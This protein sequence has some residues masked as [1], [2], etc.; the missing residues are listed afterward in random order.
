MIRC[1]V[2]DFDGVLVDSNAVKHHA[3]FDVFAPVP[4]AAAIVAEVLRTH[5]FGNRYDVIGAVLRRLGEIR[6]TDEGAAVARYAERYNEI[7]EEHAATCAEIDGASA[8]LRR[9]AD[10]TPLYVNSATPEAPLRRIVAR[11]AWQGLFR[12]VFG[13]PA[14]KV[15]NLERAWRDAGVDAAEAL[16]V[17]DREADRRAA[18]ACGCPFIGF[19]DPGNDFE[20]TVTRVASLRE[21]DHLLATATVGTDA[22]WR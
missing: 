15:D 8:C 11:R 1:L 5:R 4:G 12:G 13:G 17:G 16:F 20:A 2:L 19:Q 9:W 3:Y 7:C 6:G 10:R 14:T 18:A 22:P 21:L